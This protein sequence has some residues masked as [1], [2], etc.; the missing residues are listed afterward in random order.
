MFKTII[1]IFMALMLVACGTTNQPQIKETEVRYEKIPKH[2]TEKVKPN[3][4][5]PKEEYKVLKPHEKET[6]LS[7][8]IAHLLGV[9]K[10]QNIKFEKIDKLNGQ[11]K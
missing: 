10:E 11:L 3:K 9:V 4:P 2:L 8:Y 6:Y 5:M 7:D 1:A